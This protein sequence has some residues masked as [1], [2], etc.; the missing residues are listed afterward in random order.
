MGHQAAVCPNGT[1][2]WR[3]VY[4][5]KAF[6][7]IPPIYPDHWKKLVTPLKIDVDDIAKNAEAYREVL[8][9]HAAA[10][11]QVECTQCSHM[12]YKP[13]TQERRKA[14]A[15]NPALANQVVPPTVP[16][17]TQGNTRGM[18]A[19][20]AGAS[21]PGAPELPNG[22]AVAKDAQGRTYYWH[23]TTKKVQWDKP[24]AATPIT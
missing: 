16:F 14:V 21:A 19:A 2:D 3:A 5:D 15:E 23:T 9:E 8:D 24:T 20:A 22:W 12:G 11:C 17:A 6:V 13:C 4:G 1:I 7:V 18:V 10:K